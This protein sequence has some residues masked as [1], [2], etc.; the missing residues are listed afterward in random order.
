MSMNIGKT[1]VMKVSRVGSSC[2]VWV[3]VEAVKTMKYLAVML[4]SDGTMDE[5]VEHRIGAATRMIGATN[6]KLMEK[7]ELSRKMKMKVFNACIVPTL[8]MQV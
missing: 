3:Q 8:C 6:R 5:E 2:E 4:G 1:K 7:K